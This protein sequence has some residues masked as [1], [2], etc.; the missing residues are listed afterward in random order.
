MTEN[1]MSI[2]DA[3][4]NR[5]HHDHD[6]ANLGQQAPQRQARLAVFAQRAMKIS[7][8][9]VCLWS[10]LETPWEWTPGDAPARVAAL[11]ASKALLLAMGAAAIWGVRYARTVFV[12]LCAASV[13]AVS[14]TLPFVY[15]ISH[16]FFALSLVECLLKAAVVIS[17]VVWYVTKTHQRVSV[18]NGQR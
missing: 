16:T 11:L 6:A 14:L 3:W 12:L 5:V 17:G 2:L 10:L 9:L 4:G 18:K 15:G 1:L 7:A 8:G 13:L